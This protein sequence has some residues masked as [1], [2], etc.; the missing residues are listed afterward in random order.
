MGSPL[1]FYRSEIG[2]KIK[3]KIQIKSN[4]SKKREEEKRAR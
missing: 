3:K 4:P 1:G 2:M